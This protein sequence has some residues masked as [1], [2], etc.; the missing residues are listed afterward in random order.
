MQMF[1]L[2][3][4]LITILLAALWLSQGFTSNKNEDGSVQ[5]STYQE[6]ID[7]AKEAADLMGN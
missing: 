5:S 6:S 3:A 1:G 2:I 7:A 4:L